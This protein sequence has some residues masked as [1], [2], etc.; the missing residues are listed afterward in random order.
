MRGK[1]GSRGSSAETEGTGRQHTR[2]ERV[3]SAT[4]NR[5]SG[6]P[7]S[8]VATASD[9]H[10]AKHEDNGSESSFAAA[11]GKSR[12]TRR[13]RTRRK[14]WNL[15]QTVWAESS[16]DRCRGCRRWRAD[17]SKGYQVCVSEFEDEDGEEYQ[18]AYVANIQT[19]RS[20]W[21]CPVCS[22]KIRQKRAIQIAKA[23]ARHLEEGGGLEFMMLTMPHDRGDDLSGLLDALKEGWDGI[24]KGYARRKDW[25]RFGIEH[26]V[27]ALDLT[28]STR[29]GWHPHYHVVLFTEE[30]LSDKERGQ[31]QR[32][33]YNRWRKGVESHGYRR[34]NRAGVRIRPIETDAEA[35]SVG[36]Y[37]AEG[38]LI[39]SEQKGE[40]DRMD[41]G[42][43]MARNDLKGAS[44]MTPWDILGALD[45]ARRTVQKLEKEADE[46]GGTEALGVRRG[47]L[48]RAREAYTRYRMLW[49]EYEQATKGRRSIQPSRGLWEEYEVKEGQLEDEELA[50]EEQDG[51]T[52]AELDATTMEWVRRIPGGFSSLLEAAED[53]T[54]IVRTP[55]GWIEKTGP[56]AEEAGA[57]PIGLS[58]FISAV[59]QHYRLWK[60]NGGG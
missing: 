22:A 9:G 37:T 8:A 47:V 57:S 23:A 50:E 48:E 60:R 35:R 24:A 36:V 1:W 43:E 44:G 56:P 20:P 12:Y 53:K 30:P 42:F 18:S 14:R 26:Y 59:R 31:M 5:T 34:P 6:H 4:C 17:R 41:V 58:E 46:H 55:E 39:G 25:E 21:G 49:R 32:R 54:H 2:G 33:F 10:L 11:E 7:E 27:R 52:L 28:W 3:E 40:P 15:L 45:E 38:V 16:V 51:E 19:C 13:Q 29:N